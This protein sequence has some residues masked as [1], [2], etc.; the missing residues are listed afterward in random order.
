MLNQMQKEQSSRQLLAN[1]KGMHALLPHIQTTVESLSNMDWTIL[2]RQPPPT[3][4]IPK[5]DPSDETTQLHGAATPFGLVVDKLKR[6]L[7][8]LRAHYP[9][10]CEVS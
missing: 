3:E 5:V 7:K 1:H 8:F 2:E 6:A 4:P 10:L 9:K